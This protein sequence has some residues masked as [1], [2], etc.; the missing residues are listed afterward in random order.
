MSSD[1]TQL[2]PHDGDVVLLLG[3]GDARV[4]VGGVRLGSSAS[5]LR[6]DP[7]IQVCAR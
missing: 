2:P 7:E 6:D 5:V 4:S 3:Q 1:V